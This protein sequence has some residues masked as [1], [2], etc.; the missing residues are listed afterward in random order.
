MQITV[1]AA[2]SLQGALIEIK[3]D[4]ESS[5]PHIQVQFN[6][7]GSGALQQQISQGAPVDLF[8]S[9]AADN[10]QKLVQE[11]LIEKDTAVDLIG[12]E[13]VL[14]IP[15]S[16]SK[17]IHSLT[18]LAFG[19]IEQIAI[20]TPDSVPAGKYARS[21]LEAEG[22]WEAAS[23]KMIYAKDVKQ[24]LTYVETGNVD[25]G[26]VYKT[27]AIASNQVKIVTAIA[28]N[29]HE[30]ILYPL[31]IIKTSKHPQEAEAFYD[32]LRSEQALK[33]FIQYGFKRVDTIN[34]N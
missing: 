19:E 33:V 34:G 10:F 18:D 28:E 22:V 31:G 17:D 2:A 26:M 13:L 8:F 6:F 1:S 27:D 32:Y 20:G 5:H 14:I 24:V 30:P 7:G 29:A 12:N 21:V 16:S 4:F 9:A 23:K 15:V 25:A 11:G 3:Q